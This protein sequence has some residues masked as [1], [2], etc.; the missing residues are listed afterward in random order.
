MKPG[1]IFYKSLCVLLLVVNPACDP[2]DKQ[3]KNSH[4]HAW[5]QNAE[6]YET[7]EEHARARFIVD[8]VA[9]NFA[10]IKLSQLARSK[11]E[12]SKILGLA[13][14][15]ESDQLNSL[16]ALKGFA[17]KNNI[18][19][20]DEEKEEAKN[21]INV[22]METDSLEFDRK[23]T[24]KLVQLHEQKIQEYKAMEKRTNDDALTQWIQDRLPELEAQLK[25][26]ND[27]RSGLRK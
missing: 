19:I 1:L 13:K 4:H 21:I 25:S 7:K 27:C 16:D 9:N 6:K 17:G 14:R 24:D 3:M 15:L 10:E 20:P 26:L 5:E 22:L 18:S 8:A 2:S 12:N 11:S 23:W